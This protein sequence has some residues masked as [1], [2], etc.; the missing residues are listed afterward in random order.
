M[1]TVQTAIDQSLKEVREGKLYEAK[2]L[3]DLF[4]QL[5]D[6]DNRLTTN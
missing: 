6:C 1:A 5:N 2:D 3:K 4:S